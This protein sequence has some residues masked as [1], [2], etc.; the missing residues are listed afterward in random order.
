MVHGPMDAYP[1]LV[2]EWKSARCGLRRLG[3]AYT[4]VS[5][6]AALDGF[7][8]TTG[9]LPCVLIDAEGLE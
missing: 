1:F 4:S 7:W 3:D 2:I 5:S 8:S 9:A 6:S